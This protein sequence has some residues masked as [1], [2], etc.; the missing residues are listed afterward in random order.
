MGE[1]GLDLWLGESKFYSDYK[2][3]ARD[4]AEEINDHIKHEYLRNEFLVIA[5]KIESTWEHADELQRLLDR[6]ASFDVVFPRI[7]IPVLL[8]YDSPCIQKHSVASPQCVREFIR[9]VTENYEYFCEKTAT[10]NT[11]VEV[12]LF[13]LPL[14]SKADLVDTLHT[15]LQALRTL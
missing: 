15:R 6:N 11:T 14:E 7:H 10:F 8:T 5:P 1:E 13:I 2:Q 9:E 3:A 4:V 12:H